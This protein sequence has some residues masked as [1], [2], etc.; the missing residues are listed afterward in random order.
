MAEKD[1]LLHKLACGKWGSFSTN[2]ASAK[3]EGPFF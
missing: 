1:V 2:V 3:K